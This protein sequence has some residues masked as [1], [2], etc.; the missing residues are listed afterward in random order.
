MER[1]G[2]EIA[3]SV[4]GFFNVIATIGLLLSRQY[5]VIQKLLQLIVLWCVPL[6]FIVVFFMLRHDTRA[7]NH[8][9]RRQAR[10]DEGG[11]GWSHHDGFD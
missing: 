3:L 1:T 6:F 10:N 8:Y 5:G 7:P 9:D 2:I 11:L 4:L